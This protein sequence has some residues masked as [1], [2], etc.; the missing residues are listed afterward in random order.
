MLVY[1]GNNYNVIKMKLTSYRQS[2]M[3]TVNVHMGGADKN[4]TSCFL[5]SHCRY[6][7]EIFW[8]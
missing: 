6:Q 3:A 5:R 8:C 7:L 1:N 2:C 4:I